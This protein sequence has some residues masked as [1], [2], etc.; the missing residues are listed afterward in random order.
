[1]RQIYV[2]EKHDRTRP[3][4]DLLVEDKK[5]MTSHRPNKTE[6]G[7]RQSEAKETIEEK[8]EHADLR[9]TTKPINK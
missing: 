3:R 4:S 5:H 7:S 6:E 2:K 1:M 9:R 8:M